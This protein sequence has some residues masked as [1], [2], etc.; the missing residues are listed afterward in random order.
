[1]R[2][3]TEW[4]GLEPM[5]RRMQQLVDLGVSE[6]LVEALRPSAELFAKRWR[7]L[8]PAPGPDHPYATGN[9]RDSIQVEQDE[10]G[11]IIFTDA[12]NEIGYPY[13][14]ALEYGTS[15]MAAQP[16]AQPAFDDTVDEAVDLALVAM[17]ELIIEAMF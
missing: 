2:L 15:T 9:Y 4:T 3:S 5:Q 17:D 10:N 16:S 8:V 6:R 11:F 12:V 1:M 13:P 14:V 7:E